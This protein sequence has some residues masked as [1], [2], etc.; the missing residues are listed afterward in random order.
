MSVPPAPTTESTAQAYLRALKSHGIDYLFA[1]SGT[2]FPPIIEAMARAGDDRTAAPKPIVV[3]HEHVAVGMAHGYY[4]ATRKPQAVM[5]HVSVGTANG[6][7]ALIN[8]Y[9]D[10]IPMLF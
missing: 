8:A 6:I 5:F 4:L 3:P 9:R 7:C 10:N 2:D 1:N